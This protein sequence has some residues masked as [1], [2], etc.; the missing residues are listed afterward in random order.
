MLQTM[1]A[2]TRVQTVQTMSSQPHHLI[3]AGANLNKSSIFTLLHATNVRR[4]LNICLTIDVNF[5]NNLSQALVFISVDQTNLLSGKRQWIEPSTARATNPSL[6]LSKLQMCG[7]ILSP[8]IDVHL[9][10]EDH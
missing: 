9:Y 4:T 10:A 7:L 3:L 2:D 5:K 8:S 6:L 1:Q